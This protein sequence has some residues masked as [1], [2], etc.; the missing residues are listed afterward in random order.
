MHGWS[1][2]TGGGCSPTTASTRPTGLW[3]HRNGLV[4]PPL[5][6][7]DLHYDGDGR[8]SYPRRDERAPESALADYLAHAAQLFADAPV[9]PDEDPTGL[10]P[11]FEHL[12]WFELPARCL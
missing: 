9:T 6:L 4:E 10:S 7:T 11:D 2:A 5:R 3:R 8:L 12:R 1:P